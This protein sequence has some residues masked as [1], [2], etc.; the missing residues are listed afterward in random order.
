M[1]D[2]EIR[3]LLCE[4]LCVRPEASEEE[5]RQAYTSEAKKW[6]PDRV[7]HNSEFAAL[8][9]KKLKEINQAYECLTDRA[10]FEKHGAKLAQRYKAEKSG[11]PGPGSGSSSRSDSGS[12]SGSASGSGSSGSASGS[13][14]GSAT[15]TS[16]SSGAQSVDKSGIVK[17]FVA[18]GIF[19]IIVVLVANL[20]APRRDTSSN[21]GVVLSPSQSPGAPLQGS[22]SSN[23]QP[24]LPSDSSIAAPP[25]SN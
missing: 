18:T 6:H 24:A 12:G 4:I 15:G 10:Q 20:T 11:G 7:Q 17:I 13:A 21:P 22:G 9:D 14:T 23:P 16:A 25:G 2:S 19:V 5:I 3:R 1:N 8:A